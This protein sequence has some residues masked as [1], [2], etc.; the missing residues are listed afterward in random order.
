M[1][2]QQAPLLLDVMTLEWSLVLQQTGSFRRAADFLDVEQSAISRRVRKL[3]DRLG[4]SLFQRTARGAKPTNAGRDFLSS[5]T[6]ALKLLHD[7]ARD[8]GLAGRGQSGRLRIGMG[9]SALGPDLLLLLSHFHAGHPD[10]RIDVVE[11]QALDH[12]SAVRD[13]QLDLAVVAGGARVV[14]LD[15]SRLW[16][17]RICLVLPTLHPLATRSAV[18]WEDLQTVRLMASTRDLGP[19]IETLRARAGVSVP[20]ES[21]AAS[22][23]VLVDLV[24]LD[25]GGALVHAQ[26]ASRL[27]NHDG[28]KVLSLPATDAGPT[29]TDVEVAWSSFNDNPVLRRFLIALRSVTKDLADGAERTSGPMLP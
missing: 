22:T 24:R 21:V 19:A 29:T 20:I 13:R 27:G 16:R 25:L 1:S 14:G 7:A 11:G 4:V 15:V 3:E 18:S 8:A 6:L 23:G 12:L 10:V 28:L 26:D 17:E 9:L 2:F 5:A